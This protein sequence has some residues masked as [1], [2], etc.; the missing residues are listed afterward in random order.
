MEIQIHA[1]DLTVGVLAV[2]GALLASAAILAVLVRVLGR[3]VAD[4]EKAMAAWLLR[5][6]A[7]WRARDARKAEL[8]RHQPVLAP[9]Q[10]EV[11]AA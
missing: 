10:A 5:D 9:A 1:N 6:A 8:E 3:K 11:E 7:G 2:L 4:V